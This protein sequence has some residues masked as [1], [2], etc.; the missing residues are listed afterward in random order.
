[1]NKFRTKRGTIKKFTNKVLRKYVKIR[2]YKTM[3]AP[4]LVKGS[5]TCVPTQ[6]DTNIILHGSKVFEGSF[7]PSKRFYL[8]S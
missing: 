6:K 8:S 7:P 5:E 1:M 3:V 4:K 2:I